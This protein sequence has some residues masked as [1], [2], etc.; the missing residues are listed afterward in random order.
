MI[1]TVREVTPEV[2]ADAVLAGAQFIDA[3]RVEV[4]AT[5]VNAREPA[6]G[7]CCTGRAGSM[8]CCA[9]ATFW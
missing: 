8:R 6:S 9:C 7:W 3:F 2:D 4:G 1:G 5:T